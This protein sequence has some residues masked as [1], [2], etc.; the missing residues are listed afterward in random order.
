MEKQFKVLV[1]CYRI[2][3]VMEI[4]VA[5]SGCLCCVWVFAPHASAN[6]KVNQLLYS[7][8][9]A[10]LVLVL[11]GKIALLSIANVLGKKI[12]AKFGEFVEQQRKQYFTQRLPAK[13]DLQM[14]CLQ[15]SEVLE[16]SFLIL[17][18]EKRNQEKHWYHY[19]QYFFHDF[20]EL[21]KQIWFWAPEHPE[22]RISMYTLWYQHWVRIDQIATNPEI[23]LVLKRL[24]MEDLLHVL[25]DTGQVFTKETVQLLLAREALVGDWKKMCEEMVQRKRMFAWSVDAMELLMTLNDEQ[26]P[27]Y[28]PA[29]AISYRVCIEKES[30]AIELE[31]QDVYDQTRSQVFDWYLRKTYFVVEDI[32]KYWP[33][34]SEKEAESLA[35]HQGTAMLDQIAA[36][37]GQ[38]RYV[39]RE[40]LKETLRDARDHHTKILNIEEFLKEF[41]DRGQ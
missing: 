3:K 22:A 11:G 1:S 29:Y 19:G 34:L 10:A 39:S 18:W 35:N 4:V 26:M 36:A 32:A 8:I 20:L 31:E 15:F 7:Y 17:L 25:P 16:D 28:F 33:K 5:I 40:K 23:A 9:G 21:M 6:M 12:F 13:S 30:F 41:N 38:W 37:K 2:I 24:P 14:L 27:S